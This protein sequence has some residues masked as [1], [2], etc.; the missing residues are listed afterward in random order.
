M[1]ATETTNLIAIG[2][3]Y[4]FTRFCVPFFFICS[5][6]FFCSGLNRADDPKVYFLNYEKRLLL[7]F[8]V[9]N[10]FISG[11]IS[12]CEYIGN[13]PDSGVI[14]LTLLLFRRIFVIGYGVY[15]YLTA[16]I[17]TAAF[18][19]VCWSKKW[20]SLLIGAM[21]VG[22]F[23]QVGYSSFQG[24]VSA[25]PVW[26]FINRLFY[27]VF[28]WDAN[29]IMTGIPMFGIG[30]MLCK[31][32]IV[33]TKSF[34]TVGW[35]FF[36]ILRVIEYV[37]S[38]IAPTPFWVANSVSIAYIPQA[39]MFFFLAYHCRGI[40]QYS[41]AFR[42]LSTFIYL[43]HWIILYNLLN[44][45]MKLVCLPIYTPWCIPVKVIST[46]LGCMALN[47]MLKK[48]HNKIIYH[49]IGG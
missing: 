41:R 44:P 8:L 49:L 39:I 9:Y 29:F 32:N 15:W 30:W 12:A 42:Q 17:L 3:Q 2:L 18:F 5:G 13:N 4:T 22:Q 31:H 45:I 27:I 40:P 14:R 23:L 47:W 33:V 19:Y 28:S 1:H 48:T 7:L 43:S 20:N 36:T 46:L 26:D 37:L 6:Y 25:I 38:V 10:V 24:I 21:V 34:A 11:P 35:L 16:L